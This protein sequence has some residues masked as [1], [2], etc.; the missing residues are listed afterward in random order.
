MTD[1]PEFENVRE[2]SPTVVRATPRMHWV[3]YGALGV[4]LIAIALLLVKINRLSNN[5]AQIQDSTNAQMAKLSQQIAQVGDASGVQVEAVARQARENTAAAEQRARDAARM[6]A[7]SLA[8]KWAKDQEA[9]QQTQQQVSGRLDELK[10]ASD[11]ASSKLNDISGDVGGVKGDLATTRSTVEQTASELK[12]MNGDMGV[13]SGLIATNATQLSALRE[14]GERNYLEF[15]IHK[16]GMQKVGDI[17]LALAKADT[18]R[19]RFTVDVLADDKKV[20][21]RDRTI[22]EPV[23]LY[24]AGS[25]YPYEIVVNEVKKDEVKGY[26]A[27]PK[28]TTARR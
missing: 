7:A 4:A 25:R 15:D 1:T 28:V 18:K 6:S 10:Q 26:L 20:E 19:N 3:A 13:M 11:T 24:V 17:Q 14:L 12:R 23:Q 21:K 9:Q 5:L 27:V 8:A 16:G 2:E 22:N